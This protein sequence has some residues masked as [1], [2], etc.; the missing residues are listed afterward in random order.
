MT[1]NQKRRINPYISISKTEHAKI[2]PLPSDL[3][4]AY[5][6]LRWLA[7]FRTGEIGKDQTRPMPIS[8]LENLWSMS[9]IETQKRLDA[10]CAAGLVDQYQLGA[11]GQISCRLPLS[12]ENFSILPTAPA[13]Q[14]KLQSS[15]ERLWN[16]GSNEVEKI[17]STQSNEC[18]R[19]KN[20][21]SHDS[22]LSA[23]ILKDP[24]A[25]TID[26][27][28]FEEMYD[29]LGP[30]PTSAPEQ[31]QA[32]TNLASSGDYDRQYL[33]FDVF[34][35]DSQPNDLSS[36]QKN[37]TKLDELKR[38]LHKLGFQYVEGK[39]TQSILPR[40]LN[41]YTFEEILKEAEIL[42]K[43]PQSLP[44]PLRLTEALAR[45]KQRSNRGKVAL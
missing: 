27:P 13:A 22:T 33:E 10:F 12:I 31:K 42:T 38:E 8:M 35:L 41:L 26:P 14:Q 29:I 1:T 37:L 7:N 3:V 19:G 28:T 2:R 11:N 43:D 18:S 24:Q 6:D 15:A 20:T 39:M 45:T 25:N 5:L 36:A 40:M 21:L 23:V 17:I 9:R 30:D 16:S 44:T 4:K 34:D 32:P